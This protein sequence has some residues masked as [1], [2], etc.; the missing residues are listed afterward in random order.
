M[1]ILLTKMFA[2]LVV[3]LLAAPVLAQGD[4]PDGGARLGGG[5][6]PQGGGPQGGGPGGDL[7]PPAYEIDS[8]IRELGL[9]DDQKGKY[10]QIYKQHV[11]VLQKQYEQQQQIFTPDQ[12]AKR[13]EAMGKAK[14]QGLKGKEYEQF[15]QSSVKLSPEQQKQFID[16]DTDMK[17]SQSKFREEVYQILTPSQQEKFPKANPKKNGKNPPKQ[18]GPDPKQGG[19]EQPKQGGPD[20][21][22]GGKEQPKQGQPQKQGGP[23][24]KPVGGGGPQGGNGGGNGGP[25]PQ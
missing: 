20:P 1:K 10:E 23:D 4:G 18:G 19:K 13:Q 8:S 2:L 21:K 11:P 6:G 22:Q 3:A 9:N 15:V 7:P 16:C 12:K 17:K 14:E 25:Q 24:K 5:D